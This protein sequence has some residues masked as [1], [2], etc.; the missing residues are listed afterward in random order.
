MMSR[1]PALWIWMSFL[2]LWACHTA[3]DQAA[4]TDF[5]NLVETY[6]PKDRD[7]WQKPEVIFRLMGDLSGKVVADVGAGTGYF[8]LRLAPRARRVLALEIDPRFIHYIDSVKQVQ[9]ADSVIAR[10]ETR[11]VQ[12]DDP[13]LKPGE[14][15]YVLIVNTLGYIEAPEA[16]LRKLKAGMKQGGRVLIVDYRPHTRQ[17]FA[18]F[19]ISKET[20][21]DA[22]RRAGF[23]RLLTDNMTLDYQYIILAEKRE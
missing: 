22:L 21:E 10:L 17:A 18:K 11:L 4:D 14:V 5:E 13:L 20:V 7:V 6:E 3:T 12:P 9:L 19:R 1:Y 2:S 8:S 16:Y 23:E 15:D